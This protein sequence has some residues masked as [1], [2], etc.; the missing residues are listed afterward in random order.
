MKITD[1]D[2]ENI[3]D[4]IIKKVLFSLPKNNYEEA[5]VIIVFGCH[6]KYLL[7]E[8]I[9]HA[10]T[11]FKN[12]KINKIILTGGIGVKGDFNESEYMLEKLISSGISKDVIII[13]DKSKTTLENIINIIDILKNNNMLNSKLVLVSSEAHLRRISMQLKKQI[14]NDNLQIIFEYPKVSVISFDKIV[15][16]EQL[17]DTAVNEVKKIIDLINNKI[18]DDELI[19]SELK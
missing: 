1:I 15:N 6:L 19:D 7:D 11:V 2:L 16:N 10:I 4:D 13:E 5:D 17:R 3:N 9:N 8:R 14:G 18:I 12:K